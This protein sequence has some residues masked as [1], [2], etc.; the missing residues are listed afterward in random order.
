VLKFC[1]AEQMAL[2]IYVDSFR[3]SKSILKKLG[4]EDARADPRNQSDQQGRVSGPLGVS[5]H[6]GAVDK[7]FLKIIQTPLEN[8]TQLHLMNQTTSLV[9]H[10]IE[11]VA[12]GAGGRQFQPQMFEPQSKRDEINRTNWQFKSPMTIDDKRQ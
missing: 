8:I 3:D 2:A 7:A 6:R 5:L 9:T 1:A 11:V 4:L 12:Q 10:R